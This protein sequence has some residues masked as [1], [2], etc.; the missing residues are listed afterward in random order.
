VVV[1]DQVELA[2][3]MIGPIFGAA[4]SRLDN[5]R[6][7]TGLRTRDGPRLSG[8]AA[9]ALDEDD[10]AAAA[11][12]HEDLEPLVSS[13]N[14]RTSVPA[15]AP[16]SCRHTFGVMT[17]GL[18]IAGTGEGNGFRSPGRFPVHPPGLMRHLGQLGT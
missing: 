8:I 2:V 14:T 1:R 7:R 11:G 3:A 10:S 6:E 15:A 13:V 12:P 18:V 5:H 9:F 16:T 17:G 4:P